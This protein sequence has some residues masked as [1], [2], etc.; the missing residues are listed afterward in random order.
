MD[1]L[2][3]INSVRE[4]SNRLGDIEL[5]LETQS[6]LYQEIKRQIDV[7]G[8]G[9]IR[10]LD[11]LKK[12]NKSLASFNGGLDDN[13]ELI[14]NT[15]DLQLQLPSIYRTLNK[16]NEKLLNNQRD[17]L[18]GEV[19]SRDIAKDVL[20]AK[21]NQETIAKRIFDLGDEQRKM[22]SERGAAS[23]ST[24][25]KLEKRL[26]ILQRIQDSLTEEEKTQRKISEELNNQLESSKKIEDKIGV[27]GKILDGFRSIPVLGDM[28]DIDAADQAMRITATNASNGVRG[29]LSVLQSGIKAIG[30]SISAAMGPLLAI[31][32]A[33]S[34]VKSIVG[35]MF[36]A[37]KR[38][39]NM[40]KSFNI[41]KQ[42][43][44]DTMGVFSNNSWEAIAD[45]ANSLSQTEE[46]IL[47]TRDN[48]IDAGIEINKLLGTA[49]DF[50]KDLGE[51]GHS[52][53]AQFAKY[54]EYLQLSEKESIKLLRL[55]K[56]TGKSQDD[57]VG[58]ILGQIRYNKVKTGI[59]IDE[60]ETLQDI[61]EVHSSIQLSIKGGIYALTEAAF[62]AKQLGLS[63]N[64]VD[65]IAS[66][67]LDFESSI[68][69]ELEAELLMGKDLNLERARYY[70]LNNNILG[71]SQE[72][73]DN[74]ELLLAFT[75]GNRAAQEMYAKSLGM[76]RDEMSEMIVEMQTLKQLRGSFQAM[77]NA[78]LDTLIKENLQLEKSERLN[79]DEEK[80]LRKG[81]GTID[82]YFKLAKN[83][84]ED[85]LHMF[86]DQSLAS[87]Q[88]Q[89][90]QQKFNKSLEAAKQI[91]SNFVDGGALDN[92]ADGLIRLTDLMYGE[93]IAGKEGEKGK[94]FMKTEAYSKFTDEQKQEYQKNLS[95]ASS[96]GLLYESGPR[97]E[98]QKRQ[99][100]MIE[101]GEY[102]GGRRDKKYS[103][104]EA[105][106]II[107]DQENVPV[108][109][110][111]NG[112]VI[113]KK[114]TNA[115]VGEEGPE[116]II[117]LNSKGQDI[118][119]S[120]HKQSIINHQE[121]ENN[122]KNNV[123]ENKIVKITNQTQDFAQ[124]VG[125]LKDVKNLLSKILNKDS[126]VYMDS[127]K[128]GN[129]F[130]MSNYKVTT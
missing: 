106:K 46:G 124:M 19:N 85:L 38:V 23:G 37:D 128:V 27:A 39:T 114:I 22:E 66:S 18:T 89:D 113:K 80:R 108:T 78:K 29:Y 15:R 48:L 72:L 83:S 25:K 36:D 88:S 34:A 56:L 97:L 117:P 84:Q 96:Y 59:L 125:E 123:S 100:K 47:I 98:A 77:D 51:E 1:F 43:A 119:Q 57:I 63:L 130:N 104:S 53:V 68:S 60:R 74:Q 31:T 110:F 10:N 33:V 95:T 82:D 35:M 67:L 92:F 65:Q 50:S 64:Q 26:E 103:S 86:S 120:F 32:L 40:A 93:K 107:M 5:Q 7:F 79:E 20:R 21:L 16:L 28:L 71:L 111:A 45:K 116:A 11:A 94:E 127:R 99:K 76:S 75:N 14:K 91:F 13:Y 24:K 3:L 58:G 52:L 4:Y 8:T 54:K 81:K 101:S 9:I 61:L 118:L 105:M 69:A 30:P 49:I 70:A 122:S 62:K 129:V 12:S 102:V 112:G 109:E 115:T 90:A 42:A 126:S 44:R 55:T 41:T 17:L 87:L 121:T 6:D 2:A 73:L